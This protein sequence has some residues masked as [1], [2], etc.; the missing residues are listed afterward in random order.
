MQFLPY[1]VSTSQCIIISSI[2]FFY[3]CFISLINLWTKQLRSTLI[4]SS[5]VLWCFF[6]FLGTVFHRHH[7]IKAPLYWECCS[8]NTVL[9]GS[10]LIGDPLRK[11]VFTLIWNHHTHLEHTQHT[12]AACGFKSLQQVPTPSEKILVSRRIFLFATST[13]RSSTNNKFNI[14]LH[15]QPLKRIQFQLNR[16]TLFFFSLITLGTQ[17]ETEGNNMVFDLGVQSL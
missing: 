11:A 17:Y 12:E 14:F 1:V 8:S 3:S 15:C 4:V 6:F 13:N 2:T 10:Y 9:V 5:F 7:Q 16:T